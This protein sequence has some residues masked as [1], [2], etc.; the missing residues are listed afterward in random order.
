MIEYLESE[1]K[2]YN[3]DDKEKITKEFS[4]SMLEF[5]LGLPINDVESIKETMETYKNED[6]TY[7]FIT[8]NYTNVLD[9]IVALYNKNS[10]VISNHQGNNGGTRSNYIGKTIHIHGTTNEEMILGVNDESQIKNDFLK[11]DS[12]FLDTFI[13]KRMNKSIGQRKTEKV[14]EIVNKSHI[15]CIFG[16]SLGNTDKMWWEELIQWLVTNEKNKLVIFWKVYEDALKRKLPS[17]MIRLNEQIRKEIYEK[18]KG[19][20]DDGYYSKIKNRIMIS[21]NSDIFSLPKI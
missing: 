1:Q 16:M 20:Y 17:T 10:N 8:F 14:L 21:Y 11:E 4:R 19:K 5:S 3:F 9:K 18:G 6:F 13:K 15:I 7:S 2:K 12:L